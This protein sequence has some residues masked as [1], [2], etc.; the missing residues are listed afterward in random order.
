MKALITS[1]VCMMALCTFAQQKC[2]SS[3]KLFKFP[4]TGKPKEIHELGSAPQFDFLRYVKTADGFIY[5]INHNKTKAY[6]KD[7]D[8]LNVI[9]KEIGFSGGVDDPQFNTSALMFDTIPYGSIGNLGNDQEKYEYAILMPDKKSITGWKITSPTGCF[10]YVLTI[11]GN[12]FYPKNICGNAPCPVV[13]V[14]VFTDSVHVVCETPKIKKTY[15][16]ELYVYRM[17]SKKVDDE[18]GK[19]VKKLVKDSLLIHTAQFETEQF[20]ST[21][22]N[23]LVTAAPFQQVQTMCANTDVQV[24][25]KLSSMNAAQTT[26]VKT[27]NGVKEMIE[28]EVTKRGFR[29]FRKNKLLA[30]QPQK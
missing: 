13:T 1:I 23:Y 15:T 11:C 21:T 3:Y 19:R 22:S 10:V 18:Q 9:L 28:M 14:N 5:A 8:E 30:E 2:T 29:L 25:I 17:V 24:A 12:A 4:S 26:M 16:V 20:D 6:K 7:Y 27:D